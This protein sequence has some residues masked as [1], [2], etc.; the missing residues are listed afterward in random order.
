M[1]LNRIRSSHPYHLQQVFDNN[2][3]AH[4]IHFLYNFVQ[5]TKSESCRLKHAN[6]QYYAKELPSP[7]HHHDQLY[8]L[9]ENML[10]GY[11][12]NPDESQSVHSTY[13]FPSQKHWSPLSLS[14][15]HSSMHSEPE[16]V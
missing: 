12:A 6:R 1:F 7:R 8:Q 4:Y 5:D 11:R 2:S 13:Q 10:R 9:P 16:Y 15:V 14:S 3:P